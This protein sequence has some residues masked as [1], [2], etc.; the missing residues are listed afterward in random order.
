MKLSIALVLIAISGG[1]VAQKLPIA[2]GEYVLSSMP[3]KDA[4]FAAMMNYDG[5][6][7]GGPHVSGCVT[8]I[9]THDAAR[10]TIRTSC[11]AVGDGTP[12][13]R[14]VSSQSLT[15]KSQKHVVLQ[16]TEAGSE[17]LDYRWCPLGKP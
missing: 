9:L 12:M 14:S 3:C 8:K 4:P 17:A 2:H 5:K 6:G 16:N 1:A 15:I 13:P 7:L 11:D 10:Y